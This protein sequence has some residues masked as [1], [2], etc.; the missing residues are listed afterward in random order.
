MSTPAL[1]THHLG[2]EYKNGDLTLTVLRDVNL[3][4]AIEE[5][6]A[7]R[8][9]SGSGKTTL[10]NLLAGLDTPTAGALTV[11]GRRID[12]LG[13]RQRTRFRA[14]HLGLVF[15]DPHLIPGLSALE[16]VVLARIP[17]EHYKSLLPRARTLLSRLGLEDRL[18]HPP[19][20]LSG[21]EQ[22]RVGLARALLGNP[23]IVLADE[24]TGNLDA[25]TTAQMLH[26]LQALRA[27]LRLTLVVVTHDD[28]VAAAAQ[29]VI[30]L[31]KVH[32]DTTQVGPKGD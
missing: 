25:D 6:V 18:D 9:P 2:K 31:E 26:L 16:N 21:G 13:E 10:L 15:Q 8:G 1:E 20:H 12:Q 11:L 28:Q 32:G 27:E 22:Q 14:D 30:H 4:I 24:P 29:R 7:V 19:S 23:N 3:T 5:F 17:W